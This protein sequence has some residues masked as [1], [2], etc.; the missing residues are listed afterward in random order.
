MWACWGFPER[1]NSYWQTCHGD[2]QDHPVG[3][4]D[5]NKT[6]TG[7]APAS[8]SPCLLPDDGHSANSCLTLLQPCL[9]ARMD[10]AFRWGLKQN[11]PL[12]AFAL[13][14]VRAAEEVDTRCAF[15]LVSQRVSRSRYGSSLHA[16]FSSLLF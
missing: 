15:S 9:S 14:V 13:C 8:F 7:E 5:V 6:E 11:L 1:L 12:R 2:R 3:W 10:C 4:R 16:V